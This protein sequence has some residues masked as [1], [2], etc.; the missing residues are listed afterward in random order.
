MDNDDSICRPGLRAELE[1]ARVQI[2]RLEQSP[3]E[4]GPHR[5]R[6]ALWEPLF[7]YAADSLLLVDKNVRIEDLNEAAQ[8]LTKTPREKALGKI[9]CEVMDCINTFSGHCGRTKNCTGCPIRDTVRQAVAGGRPLHGLEVRLALGGNSDHGTMD[10]LVS[11]IPVQQNGDNLVLLVLRDITEAKQVEELLRESEE[12]FSKVFH[13]SSGPLVISDIAAGQFID[14]ND[15]WVKLLGYSRAEQIGRISKEVGIWADP[16]ER[17]RIVAKLK[18][19][20]T[21]KDEPIEFKTKTGRTLTALWSAETITMAG[22]EVMLSTICDETERRLYEKA[23]TESEERYRLLSDVTMEG[24]LI[25]RHGVVV[26]LNS[27]LTRMLGYERKELL[28]KNIMK[29]VVHE[30]DLNAVRSNI[31]KEYAQPYIVR[32]YSSNKDMFH[33]EIES[34]NYEMHGDVFRVTAIRDVTR[35]IQAEQAQKRLEGQLNQAQKME[36]VGILAGGVA[37]DFNN[38]LQAMSGN[39]Q[40]LLMNKAEDNLEAK[41]LESV[42]RSIDRAAHLVRQ[43]LLFSRK[44]EGERRPVNLNHEVEEAIKILERTIPRMVAI[45]FR[46]DVR[47]WAVTA[48]PVQIEQVLL[49]LGSNAADAMPHGGR[50]VIETRNVVLDEEFLRMN[51]EAVSG[52]FVLLTVSDTGQGMD[53]QT[54]EHAFDPFFTTKE[55]GRGT[56]L[57]LAS[58]YGIVKG[59]GG[60]ILCYSELG[61]GTAFRIYWPALGE[62]QVV[63]TALTVGP[64]A[65]EGGFET[66]LVVDDETDVRNLT[67]EVLQAFGYQVVLA[68]SGEEALSVYARKKDAVHMVI[69]D[70]GMPGMGGY[71]C[72]R[73]LL[74]IDPRVRVLIASGYS[75][76]GRDMKLTRDGA[77]GFIGKP[78][79]INELL[80]KVRDVLDRAV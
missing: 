26:D 27:A 79:K 64:E 14:V 6:L 19:H 29:L 74:A 47:T 75:A 52:K 34:R 51:A 71:Q 48:D 66:I 20:G 3:G 2:A 53:K 21:F 39:I 35:R 46:H 44:A 22:Q 55:V 16:G 45:E 72:L 58:V 77:A 76:D 38:L 60:F 7:M 50:L 31:S 33:A 67:A 37:H 61:Q 69:M 9:F 49:N 25:H 11:V 42:A 4:H 78:F 18:V 12:R 56:G 43:L 59:H 5:K 68:A 15:R 65:P 62:D 1:M 13:S 80:V 57:G 28:G 40:M 73:E 30:D 54:Q 10:A 36:A 24:V 23:L 8:Q 17:D 41:R 63:D 32:C 70:L